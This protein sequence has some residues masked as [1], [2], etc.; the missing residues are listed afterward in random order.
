[1]RRYITVP[2]PGGGQPIPLAEKRE[3]RHLR[4]PEGDYFPYAAA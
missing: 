3:D 2:G 1:M 4:L